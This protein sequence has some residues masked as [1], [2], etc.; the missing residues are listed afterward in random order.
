MAAARAVALFWPIV[1]RHE[2][3]LRPL[4]AKLRARGASVYYPAIDAE[5]NTMTFR[6]VAD[7]ATMREAGFGFAEPPADAREAAPGEL[8]VIVVPAV[9]V[10]PSG[11]RIGYGAGYYDRTLPRFAPPAT[12]FAVAYDFQ[13][14]AE[15]P[16]TEGDYPADWIVTDQRVDRAE[17]TT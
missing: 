14:L 5:T 8:D 6:L 10:A 16:V 13:L 12:T 4:D 3:D 7:P 2:V 9:A 1:E 15:V 17:G 11:H